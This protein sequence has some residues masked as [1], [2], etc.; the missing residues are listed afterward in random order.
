MTC[1]TVI[2]ICVLAVCVGAVVGYII[3]KEGEL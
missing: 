3:S 1:L 2:A